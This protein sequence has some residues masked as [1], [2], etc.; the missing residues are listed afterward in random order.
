MLRDGRNII[1]VGNSDAKCLLENWVEEV[2]LLVIYKDIRIYIV[3]GSTSQ[4]LVS[5]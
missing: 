4:S 1:P 5:V 3:H 2:D